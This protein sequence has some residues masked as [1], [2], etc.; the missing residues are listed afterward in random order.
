MKT[1][2]VAD[3]ARFLCSGCG[4]FSVIWGTVTHS[5]REM[6]KEEKKATETETEE[7]K[8]EKEMEK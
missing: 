6:K 3:Q 8:K 5:E 7:E 1:T 2:S 4:P